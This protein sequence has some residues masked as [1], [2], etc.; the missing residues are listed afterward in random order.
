MFSKFVINHHDCP[1]FRSWLLFCCHFYLMKMLALWFIFMVTAPSLVAG[2]VV[3][4]TDVSNIIKQYITLVVL[5]NTTEYVTGNGDGVSV[6]AT[7]IGENEVKL[8][9][10]AVVNVPEDTTDFCEYH[11]IVFN[12]EPLRSLC[13]DF[14]D[15]RF[16]VMY[17]VPDD[18]VQY[19]SN[20]VFLFATSHSGKVINSTKFAM[21]LRDDLHNKSMIVECYGNWNVLSIDRARDIVSEITGMRR[22]QTYTGA[23]IRKPRYTSLMVSETSI[24]QFNSPVIVHLPEE[25]TDICFR[26]KHLFI[27]EKIM[28]T[29]VDAVASVFTFPN[30][31]YE[32][33]EIFLFISEDTKSISE[34]NQVSWPIQDPERGTI[35][36]QCFGSFGQPSDA[37]NVV[38]LINDLYKERKIQTYL[39]GPPLPPIRLFHLIISNDLN[40][41]F[42]SEKHVLLSIPPDKMLLNSLCYDYCNMNSSKVI[43]S[44]LMSIGLNDTGITIENQCNHFIELLR[45]VPY[46][47]MKLNEHVNLNEVFVFLNKEVKLADLMQFGFKVELSNPTRVSYVQVFGKWDEL[48]PDQA[49]ELIMSKSLLN[50]S[51][52]N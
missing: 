5:P 52:S 24:N 20:E 10:P 1:N 40:D 26:L 36:V 33:N 29:C 2:I 31:P 25:R 44:E 35:L 6:D 47:I 28:K 38:V 27:S 13:E 42:K 32:I 39:N 21:S 43:K 9:Q 49:K 16:P 30:V 11:H 22:L 14:R 3:A 18:S 50:Y 46:P 19:D 12:N 45:Y 37:D 48:Q 51:S 23:P 4:D 8:N 41:Q 34:F 7:N 15:S 17:N